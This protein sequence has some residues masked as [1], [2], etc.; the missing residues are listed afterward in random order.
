MEILS[1]RQALA[2]PLVV[3]ISSLGSSASADQARTFCVSPVGTVRVL[4]PNQG[5]CGL[6]ETGFTAIQVIN[7]TEKTLT[8]S[9]NRQAQ[10]VQQDQYLTAGSAKTNW[11]AAVD[12]VGRRVGISFTPGTF[13]NN[14]S[15][16]C[17][18]ET[19]TKAM[20]PPLSSKCAVADDGGCPRG[21]QWF[22][23]T[24]DLT[25]DGIVVDTSDVLYRARQ[26]TLPTGTAQF[27]CGRGDHYYEDD[28]HF[29][30]GEHLTLLPTAGG[31]GERSAFTL[32]CTGF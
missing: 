20:P 14:E 30:P 13:N 24:Q 18:V 22:V 7:P 6:V 32:S 8:A 15:V 12:V 29:Q 21:Y 11:I 26:C 9:F 16:N 10:V 25:K 17:S 1:L 19:T 3:L 5:N 4:A 31:D 28:Q 2:F 23:N 27:L